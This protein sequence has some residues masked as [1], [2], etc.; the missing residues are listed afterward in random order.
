M[1]LY[2]SY[3]Q[4]LM[5]FLKKEKGNLVRT[6]LKRKRRESNSGYVFS[7]TLLRDV[8]YA[9]HNDIKTNDL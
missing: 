3:K 9:S 7:E 4:H 5:Q 1:F 2:N 6:P 8:S